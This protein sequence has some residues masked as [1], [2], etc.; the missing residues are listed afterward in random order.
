MRKT[1]A[2]VLAGG[3]GSRMK[4]GINKVLLP[5]AG[6]P[7]LIRS[8][9]A[10]NHLVDEMI[11]VC[12]PEE[13]ERILRLAEKYAFTFP[14]RLIPGGK[15]RQDSVRN[16][17][18]AL[19]C[20]P[21]DL[22]LI[23][24]G[25]RCMV[26]PEL[27]GRVLG[28]CR[29]NGTG[30]PGVPVT[31]TYKTCDSGGNVIRTV[32]RDQ[33]YEIQTPQGFTAELITRVS[34]RAA[35]EQVE[36]TDDASLL[37]YYGL[38]VRIVPGSPDNIKLTSPDDLKKAIMILEGEKES[39]MRVGMGY[40]VH[41]LVEGRKLILC[42]EEILFEKG[43]LGH[44]DADVAL[45]ALMD[46][47]LGACAMGD[48]GSHFPDT[49]PR[50]RGI[51]SMVLLNQTL[52]LLK[53][54]GFRVSNVDLT[55]VAQKPKLLPH[56]PVMIRNVADALELPENRVSIKATTTERLGF[57]GRMEGISAYAV[58]MITEERTVEG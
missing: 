43:L 30:I 53:R 16:G 14:F 41:Q 26:D 11:V 55:I 51:S 56:I 31:S 54:G 2:V 49:D 4:A 52:S 58:C 38:P 44:S 9:L 37:E 39:M 23:H 36:G 25:A 21:D 57:E 47:M 48:I 35:L 40:D 5:L 15:T 45:H 8:M 46:A 33:L 3:S 28:S 20:E 13:S 19:S 34:E 10:F 29:E 1:A 6:I 50:Y 18:L 7:V 32:P 22:I 42:G 27:I 24:D 12:R 17:L